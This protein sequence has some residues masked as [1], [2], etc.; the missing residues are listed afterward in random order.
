MPWALPLSLEL[1][2]LVTY[3]QVE[4]ALHPVLDVVGQRVAGRGRTGRP[5]RGESRSRRRCACGGSGRRPSAVRRPCPPPAPCSPGS[6][7][8]GRAPPSPPPVGAFPWT[9]P[10]A[11]SRRVSSGRTALPSPGSS[12]RGRG[13]EP[14]ERR[15]RSRSVMD[16]TMAARTPGTVISTSR[17][18]L[19]TR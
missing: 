14:T 5:A 19:G 18:H 11:V 17:F 7:G 12:P 10:T 4:E 13:P 15:S 8:C 1:M 3:Q 2:H 16:S 6:R 9:W